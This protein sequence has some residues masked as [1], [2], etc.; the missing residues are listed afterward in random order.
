MVPSRVAL[1]LAGCAA[2]L[3]AVAL[4]S[5]GQ[6]Q[7]NTLMGYP[8]AQPLMFAG[9]QPMYTAAQAQGM[10]ALS[11]RSQPRLSYFAPLQV[12]VCDPEDPHCGYGG[13]DNSPEA[14]ADP[15][16]LAI[17][18]EKCLEENAWDC[19]FP[20]PM[21][22]GPDSPATWL[23]EE[24]AG[25]GLVPPPTTRSSSNRGFQG[26]DSPWECPRKS[27]PGGEKTAVI[28]SPP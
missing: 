16:P 8:M 21:N 4:V 2:V 13:V 9:K 5:E 6:N 25:D 1:V 15:S 10:P 20:G 18:G 27:V 14:Y 7:E 11:Y 17:I 24:D 22:Y 26:P 19:P 28:Y 3:L 23:P 12:L